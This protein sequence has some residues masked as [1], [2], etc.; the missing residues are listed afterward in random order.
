MTTPV[1][2]HSIISEALD[3][4][5][6]SI[7]LSPSRRI[8]NLGDSFQPVVGEIYLRPSYLPNRSDYAAVGTTLRRHTGLYQVDVVGPTN[9][10]NIPQIE[11]VDSVIE[12]FAGQIISRN[13]L[14]IRIGSY[15]G[16]GGVPYPSPEL[17]AG[18]WRTIPITIPWWC[19][20]F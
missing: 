13:S 15:D 1:G 6:N 20:A 12:W 17:N 9:Q 7:S 2:K 14:H 4:R 16:S 11:V 19:D 3:Y 5:L 8:A 10:G 18:G